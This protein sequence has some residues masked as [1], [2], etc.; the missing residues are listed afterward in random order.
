[1]IGKSI[2]KMPLKE[3]SNS[4]KLEDSNGDKDTGFEIAEKF[5]KEEE[6]DVENLATKN[7]IDEKQALDYFLEQFGEEINLK[8]GESA[9]EYSVRVLEEYYKYFRK[10]EYEN[11]LAASNG[12]IKL[13]KKGIAHHRSDIPIDLYNLVIARMSLA[14]KFSL[15]KKY[16]EKNSEI[17][18]KLRHVNFKSGR[19]RESFDAPEKYFSQTNQSRNFFPETKRSRIGKDNF[20]TAELLFAVYNTKSPQAINYLKESLDNKVICLL[21]GGDSVQDLLNSELK[22]K[23]IINIDPYIKKEKIEK[24]KDSASI[25]YEHLS[26]SADDKAIGQLVEDGKIPKIDEIWASYSVPFYLRTQEEIAHLIKNIDSLLK[27]GGKCHI[28]PYNKMQIDNLSDEE[29]KAAV[30]TYVGEIEKLS[31]RYKL[32]LFGETLLLERLA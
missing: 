11:D 27:V 3:V 32:E 17:I 26:I 9:E 20:S 28:A 2:E 30:E 12:G 8:N 19:V 13:A 22:P 4:R 7:A 23:S 14:N 31:K 5:P 21:G 15:E 16:Q 1:M 10:K 24:I 6:K 29:A 18:E 25:P